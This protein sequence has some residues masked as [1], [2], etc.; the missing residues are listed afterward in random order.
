MGSDHTHEKLVVVRE[1]ILEIYYPTAI[2]DME[3]QRPVDTDA[4]DEEAYSELFVALLMSC[5]TS[6]KRADSTSS[7]A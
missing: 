7:A 5:S 2:D 1:T 4:A 3:A 6:S